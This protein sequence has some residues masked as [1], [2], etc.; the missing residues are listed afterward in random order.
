[1]DVKICPLMEGNICEKELCALWPQTGKMCSITQ[2]G[3]SLAS[4]NIRGIDVTIHENERT[5]QEEMK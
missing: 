1:M 3:M 4:I 5:N 2:I